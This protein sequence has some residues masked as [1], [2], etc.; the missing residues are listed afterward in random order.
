MFGN[1]A[2]L[3]KSHW[4][5]CMDNFAFSSILSTATT[6][7]LA[8]TGADGRAVIIW[9]L[10]SMLDCVLGIIRAVIFADFN[11]SKLYR[12]VAKIG[13]QMI[14][15]IVF[16]M[17][18]DMLKIAAG[19]EVTLTDWLILFFAFF[20][21]STCIDKLVDMRAPVP[22]VVLFILR[23][24]RLRVAHSVGAAVGASPEEVKCIEQTLDTAAQ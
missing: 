20:D 10:F 23:K 14:L 24:L 1:Y 13:T 22:R 11:A 6:W 17:M 2:E 12:W 4:G 18:L 3:I 16:A 5:Q 15:I 19:I 21:F 7:L 8:Y 9:L